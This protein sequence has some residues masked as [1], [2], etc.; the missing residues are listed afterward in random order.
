MLRHFTAGSLVLIAAMALVAVQADE[1]ASEG[2]GKKFSAKCPVSGSAAKQDQ[3]ADYRLGKENMGKVYFC[4]GKC[5]AAFVKDRTKKYHAK[6][7]AQLVATGQY[8]QKKC[9]LTGGPLK[10]ESKVE[11]LDVTVKFCCN[12]CKKKFDEASG[13]D[14]VQMAFA[15]KAFRKGWERDRKRKAQEKAQE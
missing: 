12:N 13:D 15:D 2:E 3:N 4:C 7:N 9:P 14:K 1:A 5:R 8:V 11:D 6:A 10:T